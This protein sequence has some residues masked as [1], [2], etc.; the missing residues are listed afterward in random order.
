MCEDCNTHGSHKKY[1]QS[2]LKVGIHNTV[3]SIATSVYLLLTHSVD[4]R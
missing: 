2:A 4:V 3:Y 1:I